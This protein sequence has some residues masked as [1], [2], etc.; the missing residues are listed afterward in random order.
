MAQEQI[1]A[2]DDRAERL[3]ADAIDAAK[4][5]PT[6]DPAEAFTDVWADGGAAWRT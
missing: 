4:A 6:A 3:V 5:A 2:V 1:V